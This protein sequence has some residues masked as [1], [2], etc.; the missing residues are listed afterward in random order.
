MEGFADSQVLVNPHAGFLDHPHRYHIGPIRLPGQREHFELN[1][2]MFTEIF[3][4]AERRIRQI[5]HGFH[6]GLELL[7]AEL[8]LAHRIQVVAHPGPVGGVEL[9]VQAG[10]RFPDVVEQ[11]VRRFQDGG[12]FPLVVALTEHA[13]ENLARIAFHRQRLIGRPIRDVAARLA[14]KFHRR[15]CRVLAQAP[16]GD[17]IDRRATAVGDV[18]AARQDAGQPGF[19]GVAVRRAAFPRLVAQAADH[20]HVFAQRFEWLQEIRKFEI[21]ADLFGL[22][23]VLEGAVRKVNEAQARLRNGGSLRQRR[24]RR[25]HGIQQRQGDR[26][27]GAFEQ[28]ASRQVFSGEKHFFLQCWGE[29]TISSSLSLLLRCGIHFRR[30]PFAESIA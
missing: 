13:V 29:L 14:A 12:A 25:D 17:L 5:D 23:F 18:A 30:F 10:R 22:P 20:G 26:R 16:R 9:A 24:T 3:R 11:T 28:G 21:T 6:A 2:E 1:I 27:A 8:D 15:H 7:H 19:F 4:G